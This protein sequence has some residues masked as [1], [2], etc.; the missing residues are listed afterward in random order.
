MHDVSSEMKKVV[1]AEM[2]W[3]RLVMTQKRRRDHNKL[4]YQVPGAGYRVPG[5][6]SAAM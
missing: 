1:E 5:P 2:K 3:N 4:P 6:P